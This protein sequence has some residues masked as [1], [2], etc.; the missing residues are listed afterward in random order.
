M[1]QEKR[2]FSQSQ[3]SKMFFSSTD[4]VR[5][6]S[7]LLRKWMLLFYLPVPPR[8]ESRKEIFLE[9]TSKE[10]QVD[11][12]LESIQRKLC[13]C[14]GTGTGS[15]VSKS[16]RWDENF[17]NSDSSFFF[18]PLLNVETFWQQTKQDCHFLKVWLR[19]VHGKGTEE[20]IAL[21]SV[22]LGSFKWSRHSASTFTCRSA[23]KIPPFPWY[24]TK[25]SVTTECTTM[26]MVPL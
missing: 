24:V 5:I 14:P 22:T 26:G 9:E 20:I 25:S 17:G 13:A 16:S 7:C 3:K 19:S 8:L 21:F 18:L 10:N 2:I 4:K 11:E 12:E 23:K 1:K 6:E 15:S